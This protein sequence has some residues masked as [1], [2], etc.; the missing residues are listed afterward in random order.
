ME[1]YQDF[2]RGFRKYTDSQQFQGY[3]FVRYIVDRILDERNANTN[4]RFSKL[5]DQKRM[6]SI[7]DVPYMYRFH[8]ER[9]TREQ[10]QELLS[11]LDS[12]RNKSTGLNNT[13]DA[14]RRL[15]MFALRYFLTSIEELPDFLK[16]S[17]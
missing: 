6:F 7:G 10:V 17:E 13:L 4:S 5:L 2:F 16:K 12:P 1:T 3:P 11:E 8:I 14:E 9:L 15:V